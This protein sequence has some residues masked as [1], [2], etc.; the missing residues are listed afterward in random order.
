ML[1]PQ[2]LIPLLQGEDK[3]S[4]SIRGKGSTKLMHQSRTS[5]TMSRAMIIKSKRGEAISPKHPKTQDVMQ[6]S[7]TVK[8]YK[9]K[10]KLSQEMISQ[11]LKESKCFKCGGYGHVSHKCLPNK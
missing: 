9:G 10:Y 5:S 2:V 7:S 4:S 11:Y 6:M 1:L 3:P 8:R